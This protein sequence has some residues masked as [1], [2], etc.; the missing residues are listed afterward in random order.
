L[1]LSALLDDCIDDSLGDLDHR[2]TDPSAAAV[3]LATCDALAPVPDLEQPAHA[4]VV[5]EAN[6]IA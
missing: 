6:R 4:L 2:F 3:E 5:V 1:A